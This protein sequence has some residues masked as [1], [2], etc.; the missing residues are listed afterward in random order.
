M[1]RLNKDDFNDPHELAKY[2]ATSGITLGEFESQFKYLVQ[3]GNSFDTRKP[4]NS[5]ARKKG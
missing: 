1:L 5:K 2:A 3:N 4:K